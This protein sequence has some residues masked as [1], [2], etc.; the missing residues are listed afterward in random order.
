M[1][2]IGKKNIQIVGQRPTI[3]KGQE[4]FRFLFRQYLSTFLAKKVDYG[5]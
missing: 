4:I 1:K 3:T 5:L 2:L